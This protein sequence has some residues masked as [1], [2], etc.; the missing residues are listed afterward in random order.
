M[1]EENE[2]TF[3]CTHSHMH[4]RTDSCALSHTHARTPKPLISAG[5]HLACGT[6]RLLPPQMDRQAT[7]QTGR[8]TD[9]ATRSPL[10]YC[11]AV[12]SLPHTLPVAV[13]SVNEWL[14]DDTLNALHSI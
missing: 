9:T 1:R 4:A 2:G 5:E 10:F 8:Q 7:R 11:R 3:T 6:F 14:I 12:C 13:C